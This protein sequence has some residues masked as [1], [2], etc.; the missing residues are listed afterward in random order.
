[1][2]FLADVS[3]A[4]V[5][6][7]LLRQT[8]HTLTCRPHHL[9]TCRSSSSSRVVRLLRGTFHRLPYSPA[10]IF[11]PSTFTFIQSHHSRPK[12]S[13]LITRRATDLTYP[14]CLSLSL[15][16]PPTPLFAL[17][18]P[19][20]PPLM[21]TPS[22]TDTRIALDLTHFHISLIQLP[23]EH[24]ALITRRATNL[25]PSR[26]CMHT[27]VH[28]PTLTLT[29]SR[30]HQPLHPLTLAHHSHKFAL[31]HTAPHTHTLSR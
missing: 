25:R 6:V 3:P 22:H 17:H 26:T 21:Y 4:V 14:V 8:S 12:H 31:A 20:A 16:S 13:I 28:S 1:M 30:S 10:W 23:P 19:Y 15:G 27:H 18:S 2:A 24:P 9:H 7:L 11:I 5:F 29:P